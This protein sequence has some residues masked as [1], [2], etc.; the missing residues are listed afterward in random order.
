MKTNPFLMKAAVAGLIGAAA[1]ITA[2][3]HAADAP[4]TDKGHCVGA[5]SCKG[6]GACKQ[7]GKNDCGGKNGCGGKG[8]LEKSK[9]ECDKMSKKDKKIH[10]EAAVAD[11]KM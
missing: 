10:F 6:K 3:A 2:P 11:G 5:N 9:A 7:V 4:A 1:L 8:Y